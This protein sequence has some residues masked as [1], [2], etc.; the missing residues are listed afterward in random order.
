MYLN[1]GQRYVAGHFPKQKPAFFDESKSV[2]AFTQVPASEPKF[3]QYECSG[4]PSTGNDR[5]HPRRQPGPE[6]VHT[7]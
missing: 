5:H 6:P 2:Q 4:C 3:P 7:A 1:E